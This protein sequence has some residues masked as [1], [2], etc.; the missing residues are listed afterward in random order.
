[1][2]RKELVQETLMSSCVSDRQ[3]EIKGRERE[4]DLLKKT[5]KNILD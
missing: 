1:M 2:E 3:E 4:R 5:F